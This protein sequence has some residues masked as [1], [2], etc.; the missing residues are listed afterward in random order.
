MVDRDIER[1][2]YRAAKERVENR[3]GF[4]IHLSAYII[5]SI[6]FVVIWFTASGGPGEYFW[7]AWPIIAWGIG[8]L[9]H[10]ISVFR[11]DAFFRNYRERKMKQFIAEERERLLSDY[12]D[13]E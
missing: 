5:F 10:G 12:R 3:I 1:E 2:A 11:N 6:I 4:F 13:K 8:V 9:F 7:P